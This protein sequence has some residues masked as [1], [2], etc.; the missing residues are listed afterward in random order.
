M[1]L[2]LAPSTSQHPVKRVLLS[3]LIFS[4]HHFIPFIASPLSCCLSSFAQRPSLASLATVSLPSCRRPTTILRVTGTTPAAPKATRL[5]ASPALIGLAPSPLARNGPPMDLVT[6]PI[7]RPL[8]SLHFLSLLSLCSLRPP[9]FS[10]CVHSVSI[11]I[12]LHAIDS[13]D[14]SRVDPRTI[15]LG[16]LL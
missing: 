2:R 4:F 12:L 9:P 13:Y 16:R 1:A 8:S 7:V 10:L 15:R 14:T 11:T 3:S 6:V 5:T